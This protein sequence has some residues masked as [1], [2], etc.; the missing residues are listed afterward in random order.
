MKQTD[1]F[2]LQASSSIP[3]IVIVGPTGSGKSDLA[4][5][6]AKKCNGEIVSADSRQVYKGLDLGSGKVTK[7]ERKEVVHHLL[8]VAPPGR[9]FTV[10]QFK[11][12]AD[13]A[14]RDIWKRGKI[15]FLV[16]G[17]HLYVKAVIEGYDVPEVK[18]DPKLRKDLEGHSLENLLKLLKLFDPA[19]YTRIDKK[20]PRRVIRALEIIY[21]TGKPIPA[22]RKT[23][24]YDTLILGI[25][26]P[27]DELYGRIDD[28]VDRRV[29]KGM[30]AE[31]RNLIKK[32]VS[33]KWLKSLGLEYRFLTEYLKGRMTKHEA[34]EK[35]K[36]A[37]HDFARRQ[38]TWYRKEKR[39]TWI[40][41]IKEAEKIV[42][43]FLQ[44][45]H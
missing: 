9:R 41:S 23:S 39:I 11:K 21:H 8:D 38:L 15:P 13:T 30:I 12:K 36:N 16:G 10:A 29:K 4:I 7:K 32:G 24:S 26:V 19:T 40:R 20:N 18:P 22:L 42:Q 37:T 33:K 43:E 31:V 25:D 1:S 2:K 27:R 44:R 34:L 35:L 5:K 3:L 6:L 14:I 17:S 28:R 45:A